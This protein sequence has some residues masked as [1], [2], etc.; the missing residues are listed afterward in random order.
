MSAWFYIHRLRSGCL[1]SGSTSDLERRIE[2]H[3]HGKGG[4]TTASDPPAA[5]IFQEEFPTFRDARRRE[6]QV[7][8]WSR[9]KKESLAA[10]DLT[11]LRRFSISHDHKS[12]IASSPPQDRYT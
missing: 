5:L 10:G 9:A 6:A 11:A 1:Y 12:L 4:Y 2:E 8:R 7:K 3:R